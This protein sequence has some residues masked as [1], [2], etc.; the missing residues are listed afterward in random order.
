MRSNEPPV[1]SATLARCGW[2]AARGPPPTWQ[3][4][5]TST[6]FA[7]HSEADLQG[8][9]QWRFVTQLPLGVATFYLGDVESARTVLNA[10]AAEQP[11][12][13]SWQGVAEAN[14]LATWA[15]T[16]DEETAQRAFL[17]VSPMLARDAGRNLAG[18]WLAL[19]AAVPAL[20]LID[21]MGHAAVALP[22][23]AGAH[24]DRPG[25]RHGDHWPEHASVERGP[26]GGGGRACWSRDGPLRSR[27]AAGRSACRTGCCSPR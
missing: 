13:S 23:D 5:E 6:R 22:G 21:E 11:L 25:P 20:R 7:Q 9:A 2:P 19:M 1:A 8:P 4:P 18:R 16:G 3:R 27:L 14:L 10:A 15:Y 24:R 17:R 26:C 12:R